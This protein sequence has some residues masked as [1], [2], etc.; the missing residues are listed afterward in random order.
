MSY[1]VSRI[2]ISMS[3][4]LWYVCTI[5]PFPQPKKCN[6]F[7]SAHYRFGHVP[8]QTLQ[9]MCKTSKYLSELRDVPM[10]KDFLCEGCSYGKATKSDKRPSTGKGWKHLFSL[11]TWI[12]LVLLGQPLTRAIGTALCSSMTTCR[13]CGPTPTDLGTK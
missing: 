9:K 1:Q 13:S 7:I 5:A 11:D 2:P 10:P 12:R 8:L 4:T 6:P 3:G